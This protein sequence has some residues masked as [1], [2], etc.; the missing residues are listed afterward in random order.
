MANDDAVNEILGFFPKDVVFGNPWGLLSIDA[1]P[2]VL[3]GIAGSTDFPEFRDPEFRLGSDHSVCSATD[4]LFKVGDIYVL[5]QL[6]KLVVHFR[7]IWNFVVSRSGAI[8]RW[9]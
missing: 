2:D 6:K 3:S 1:S 4:P 7:L 9:F 8:L 5:L